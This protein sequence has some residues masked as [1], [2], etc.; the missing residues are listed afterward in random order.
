MSC[1]RPYYEDIRTVNENL[2]NSLRRPKARRMAP[3]KEFGLIDLD[4]RQLLLCGAAA[5]EF[6]D[7]RNVGGNVNFD[8]LVGGG[9]ADGD[10]V[11]VFH[12]AKLLELLDALEFAGRKRG[13][14]EKSGAAE[15]VKSDVL[16]MARGDALTGVTDPRNGRAGKIEGIAVEVGD[17]FDDVGIHDVFGRGDGNAKSGDLD[18][19]RGGNEGID[20]GV[21]DFSVNEGEIALDVD[22]NIRGNVNGDFS[23]AI[24]AGAML[25][26]GHDD[27]AVERLDGV[28]D[29]I[30]VRG[31][32]NAGSAL[33]L[34][35]AF[36]DVLNH[37]TAS[38]GR[39]GFPGKAR[40]SVTRGN[41]DENVRL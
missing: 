41:D 31:D 20:D 30:V 23:D 11:A 21:N 19:V 12:P 27:V 9:F 40:R 4:Q 5:E 38:N 28:A 7:A 2:R 36:K 16:E 1:G 17:D 22:V 10:A 25:G 37:G 15:R 14:F 24:G 29:A 6:F 34:L 26:A 13:K 33:A 39:K 8:A 18:I 3:Q 35:G 32:D